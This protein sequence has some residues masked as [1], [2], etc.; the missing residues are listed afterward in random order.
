M[1]HATR[2]RKAKDHTAVMK[3]KDANGMSYQHEDRL[4]LII[5]GR[6][7]LRSSCDFVGLTPPISRYVTRSRA[8]TLARLFSNGM[9]PSDT[10]RTWMEEWLKVR[11][12]SIFGDTEAK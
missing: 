10:S 9:E 1:A 4:H 8:R 12:D 7:V 2:L 11:V 5:Q 3:T 6:H